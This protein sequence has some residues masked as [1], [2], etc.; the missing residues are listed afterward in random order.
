MS[1]DLTLNNPVTN[2][3]E[4]NLMVFYILIKAGGFFLEKKNE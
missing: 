2:N 3:S 4:K 1:T